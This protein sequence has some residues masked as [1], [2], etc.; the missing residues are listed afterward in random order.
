MLLAKKCDMSF[1][2]GHNVISV[3]KIFRQPRITGEY[4]WNSFHTVY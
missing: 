1:T 3:T 2:P 4:N